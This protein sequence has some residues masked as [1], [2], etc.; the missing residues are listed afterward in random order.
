MSTE[1]GETAAVGGG[2]RAG[3]ILGGAISGAVGAIA[4]GALVWFLDPGIVET[5]IP[6][7]YGLEPVGVVGW[8]IH[9]AHGVV[10]GLAFGFLVTR[11]LILETLWMTLE[12]DALS[13]TGVWIRV[14]GAGFVF[15]LAVWAIL[16]VIVLPVWAGTLGAEPA[17]EFPVFA[18]ESLLGHL[19]F[20]TVLGLVFA[21]LVDLTDRVAE[22]PAA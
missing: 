21:T 4:F 12:T 22:N 1:P 18:A 9:V 7:I 10:L 8:G 2:G 20:G 19:L 11:E 5:T 14:V 3:W 17:G 16:P 13:R 15:G 6:E